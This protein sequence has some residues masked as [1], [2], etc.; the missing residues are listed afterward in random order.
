[1]DMKDKEP[2]I[3]P[4]VRVGSTLTALALAASQV[5]CKTLG[6]ESPPPEGTQTRSTEVV[7]PP[8]STLEVAAPVSI[9]PMVEET[10]V[11]GATSTPESVSPAV[12]APPTLEQMAVT[13]YG[14]ELSEDVAVYEFDKVIPTGLARVGIE[15]TTVNFSN[16]G[17]SGNE[18]FW[19]PLVTD[20]EGSVVWAYDPVIGQLEWPVKLDIVYDAQGL[21]IYSL[22]TEGLS[23]QPVPDSQ[24]AR[25]VW[26][27]TKDGISGKF[28]AILAK[29]PITL[30]DG[31][32]IYSTYWDRASQ[33][34]LPTPGL[35]ELLATPLPEAP[36][37]V[38]DFKDPEV[39]PTKSFEY[40][41]STEFAQQVLDWETQGRFP[42][43]P[44]TAVPIKTIEIHLDTDAK[45][46]REFGFVPIYGFS[47]QPSKPVGYRGNLEKVPYVLAGVW[48]TQYQGESAFFILKKWRNLDNSAGFEGFIYKTKSTNPK[49]ITWELIDY[50]FGN[51]NR[52]SQGMYF[53]NGTA[54][55]G[56]NGFTNGCRSYF[57]NRGNPD[58]VFCKWYY[59]NPDLVFNKEFYYRWQRTGILSNYITENNQKVPFI[60]I[61]PLT[62]LPFTSK[63]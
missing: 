7:P 24:G 21:P 26:G 20:S 32:E 17:L 13:G 3:H 16:N 57:N 40:L 33:S 29:D 14:G 53:L 10:P 6:I 58:S 1:M 15:N 2:K 9:Q 19:A 50:G 60:P 63:Q 62:S 5:G 47:E 42:E 52:S 30:P 51:E 48:K 34:W 59:D 46:L 56:I 31:R 43:V 61:S 22:H 49:A 54:T 37:I 44:E 11:A 8:N 25:I 38:W 23:Y 39:L 4:L 55:V 28:L 35:A 27:G 12:W 18:Y 45:F 36:E 41:T